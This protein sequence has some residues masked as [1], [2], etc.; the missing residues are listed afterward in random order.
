MVYFYQLFL[1]TDDVILKLYTSL[2][3]KAK[4]TLFGALYCARGHC[5]VL[6]VAR[7]LLDFSKRGLGTRLSPTLFCSGVSML[8]MKATFPC[9]TIS[10]PLLLIFI[11]QRVKGKEKNTAACILH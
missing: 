8:I 7:P 2:C 4:Y 3:Q 6:R 5:N 10:T 9:F 11:L 1:N